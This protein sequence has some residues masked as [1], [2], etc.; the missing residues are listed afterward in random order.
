MG[1]P[2][3]QSASAQVC[4]VSSTLTS[5]SSELVITIQGCWMHSMLR[6][7]APCACH[8]ATT[9]GLAASGATATS[10][11]AAFGRRLCF[12]EAL[13][14]FLGALGNALGFRGLSGS[15]QSSPSTSDEAL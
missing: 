10:S 14:T 7:L 13:E 8:C 11:T 12:P 1:E 6:M 15:P 3:P 4:N 5:L 2:H 9:L